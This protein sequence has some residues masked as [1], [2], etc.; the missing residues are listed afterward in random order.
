MSYP[1]AI[2]ITTASDR[3][4]NFRRKLS[5]S[6]NPAAFNDDNLFRGFT[7]PL[8]DLVYLIDLAH[9]LKQNGKDIAG[10]KVYLTHKYDESFNSTILGED[11]GIVLN[12]LEGKE[13]STSTDILEVD[14]ESVVFD[15]SNPCPSGC[16]SADTSILFSKI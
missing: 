15:F 11:T 7:L 1:T 3:T 8:S 5:N 14:N 2:N 4:Q 10:V 12:L 9:Q 16:N 13:I 6:N